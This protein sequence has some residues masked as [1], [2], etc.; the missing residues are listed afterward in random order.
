M[1]VGICKLCK[2]EKELRRSHIIPEFMY[3]N[4]YDKEPKKFNNIEITLDNSKDTKVKYEQKG[5]R[6][7]LLCGDCEVLLSK[8]EKYAAE[9]IYAKNKNSKVVALSKIESNRGI[10]ICKLG[11]ISYKDFKIFLFS[12]LWRI[13]I[14]K[15]FNIRGI[16]D[17]DKIEETLRQAILN[18]DPL[19]YDKYACF[20]QII[21]KKM[22]NVMGSFILQ[23]YFSN[24]INKNQVLNCLIDGYFFSFYLKSSELQI[25]EKEIFLK[26]NGEMIITRRILSPDDKELWEMLK[27]IK[28]QINPYF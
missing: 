7:Y 26:Q 21:D 4:V 16:N 14:S 2:K 23:P 1:K 5:I 25:D 15:T 28:P 12:L 11:S 8:Y 17:K 24:D 20:M 19:E 9:I 10:S 13:I 22:D 27:L 6:E 3:E 18:E